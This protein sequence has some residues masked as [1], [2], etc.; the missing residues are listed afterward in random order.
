MNTPITRPDPTEYPAYYGAYIAKVIGD[1]LL[2]QLMAGKQD[3]IAY[4]SQIPAN[5]HDYKYLP[6][7]WTIKEVLSHLIDAER[8]FAYRALRIARNDTTPLAGFDENE[9]VP[10]SNAVNRTMDDLL[11][12]YLAVRDS[13]IALF[14][15]FSPE[16]AFRSGI[17][18]QQ[19][20]TVRAIGYIIA[21]HELHHLQVI[22]ERYL[23]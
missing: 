20:I 9:Y 16:M 7:K 10:E 6:D 5:K 1:D 13:S 4:L 22:R 17:A 12:E 21:G 19:P 2:P 8:I 11:E 18:N 15:S 3:L 23:H 14:R